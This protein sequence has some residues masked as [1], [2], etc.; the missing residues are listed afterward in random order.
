[1]HDIAQNFMSNSL[2]EMNYNLTDFNIKISGIHPFNEEMFTLAENTQLSHPR[3]R[4]YYEH[5]AKMLFSDRL[6]TDMF[7]WGE[8]TAKL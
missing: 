7:R 4:P 6:H 2:L 3:R 8:R 5:I 1:M